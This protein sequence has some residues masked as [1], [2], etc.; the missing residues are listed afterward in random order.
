MRVKKMCDV[1]RI[2]L[3]YIYPFTSID[4][5]FFYCLPCPKC[6]TLIILIRY[7]MSLSLK[8]AVVCYPLPFLYWTLC[9]WSVVN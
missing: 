5:Y 1:T 8:F 7:D 9:L 6:N 2:V 3:V 4:A